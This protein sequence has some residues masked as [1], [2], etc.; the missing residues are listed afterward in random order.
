MEVVEKEKYVGDIV[1]GDGKHAKNVSARRS[2]GLGMICEIISIIDSLCLGCH[3]F[4]TALI[5]RQSMLVSVML[6]NSEAWLRLTKSD[7]GKI[8]GVDRMF[9]RRVFQVPNSVPISFLYLETGCT[10]MRY[11]IKMRRIM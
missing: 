4:A 2:K 11:L 6:S 5:M 7:L 8:E 10:P 3:Y 1:T 9:L